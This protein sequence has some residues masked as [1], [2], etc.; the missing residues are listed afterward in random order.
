MKINLVWKNFKRKNFSQ[1]GKIE[2]I[3]FNRKLKIIHKIIPKFK[4]N[5]RLKF[6]QPF[7]I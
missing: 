2:T 5:N 1:V 3:F 7:F 4:H 6:S